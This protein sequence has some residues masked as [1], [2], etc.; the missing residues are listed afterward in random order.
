M[1]PSATKSKPSQAK[2]STAEAFY[3]I[4]CALSKKDRLSVARYILQDLEIIQHLDLPEIPN[5][6]TL[7]AFNEDKTRMPA[8]ES[9]QELREDLLS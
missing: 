7:K 5:D 4:F 6:V 1:A 3:Q 9:V 2:V 8:F